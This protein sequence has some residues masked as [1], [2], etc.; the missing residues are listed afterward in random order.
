MP[1]AQV[2]YDNWLVPGVQVAENLKK[3]E[4]HFVNTV[5]DN[6]IDDRAVRMR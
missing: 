3:T 4:E 5:S 2:A 6:L 1:S